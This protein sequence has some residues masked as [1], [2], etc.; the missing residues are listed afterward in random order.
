[1]LCI[2]FASIGG[3]KFGV[4]STYYAE[5]YIL[6]INHSDMAGSTWS[7]GPPLTRGRAYHTCNVVTDCKGKRQVVVVGGY[8]GSDYTNSVEI[9]DVE[10]GAWSQGSI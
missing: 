10:S 9:Y 2:G 4:P 3:L 7:S 5:T 8:A 1:M 6:D